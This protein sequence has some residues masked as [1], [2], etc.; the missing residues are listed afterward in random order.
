MS[1]EIIGEAASPLETKK[2]YL[3]IINKAVGALLIYMLVFQGV[4][5]IVGL[6]ANIAL[7]FVEY[8]EELVMNILQVFCFMVG[9][10]L[11]L[12]EAG[13]VSGVK[14]NDY[15]KRGDTS[16]KLIGIGIILVLGAQMIGSFL[17]GLLSLIGESAGLAMNT[18]APMFGDNA[19]SNVLLFLYVCI[20]APLFEECIFRGVVLKSLSK[21]NTTFAIIVS[22]I[23]FG[24]YHLNL[25]QTVNAFLVGLVFALIAVKSGSVIPS[26]V[27]HIVMNTFASVIN[28]AAS[29]MSEEQAGVVM[30]SIMAGLALIG[31]ITFIMVRKQL[32]PEKPEK[33]EVKA[34]AVIWQSF[35]FWIFL[36]ITLSISVMTAVGAMI[37]M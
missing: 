10:P 13:R 7:S 31:I 19:L 24:L 18:F 20:L 11:A 36:M 1:E 30:P 28:Y 32:L 33:S 21:I 2:N 37:L 23:L 14:R 3:S 16:G 15:L 4:G 5:F 27:A 17:G 8:D 12:I 9:A 25:F 29:L 22:A 6:V 26:I 35:T 34:S